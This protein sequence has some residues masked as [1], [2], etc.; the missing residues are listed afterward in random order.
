MGPVLGPSDLCGQRP[1]T[2]AGDPREGA[3][4]KAG[5]SFGG[6]P[7]EMIGNRSAESKPLPSIG[8]HSSTFAAS[9]LPTLLHSSNRCRAFVVAGE[10]SA[11]SWSDPIR[12]GDY[13]RFD[14]FGP[15]GFARGPDGCV[16]NGCC[17]SEWG[18]GVRPLAG[19]LAG[20]QPTVSDS[21][22]GNRRVSVDFPNF[23][24][25]R[26]FLDGPFFPP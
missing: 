17:V 2:P 13:P 23:F 6:S 19:P 10:G 3:G 12:L 1:V 16:C 5:F 15:H 26:Q 20:S 7:A 4:V 18:V 22:D 8:K 21:V 11:R 14:T 25:T 24:P 9:I